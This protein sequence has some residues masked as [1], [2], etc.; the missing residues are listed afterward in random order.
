MKAHFGVLSYKGTGHLNPLI[1][2]SRQLVARGHRVTFFQSPEFEQKI[3]R[4]GLEFSAIR[5]HESHSSHS[6]LK[7][8]SRI[9]AMRNGVNRI[10]EDMEF[11]LQE[12]P[13]AIQGSGVDTL[14]IGEI[15][16]AG[17]TL[18]EM[19]RLPY[20]IVS[21]SIPHNFGW[22]APSFIAPTGSWLDRLQKYALEVS[23]LR[24]KGP[25]R[26]RLDQY[27][28][29]VG[30]GPIRKAYKAFPS[31]AHI[32]QVPQCLDLPRATLPV[33]FFYT[34]PFVDENTRPSIPF[35]W[36]RLD[37][38]PIIYASLGTTRKNDP[39]IFHRI[40]EACSDLDVQL[41]ITLGGRRDPALFVDLPGDPLVVKDAPQLELLKRAEI[42]IT[43]A[44]PNTVLETLMQGKPMLALPMV[45][46]QP[47]VATR[48]A[49]LNAAEVLSIPNRSS[50]QIRA[51]LVRLQSDASYR[52]AAKKI[53][54]QMQSIHGLK[55]ASDIIEAA[56]ARHSSNNT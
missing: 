3:L 5:V 25:V 23:V 21:T 31:L 54:A 29:R 41:V 8:S 19:L 52:D 16:L 34:A 49:R 18:A 4:H 11:F 14:L 26:R 35:P 9:A 22:N 53:Q 55:R 12:L 27:R 20:F 51:A 33:N 1:A 30:L 28:S 45:L 39:A 56:L 48:L 36:D 2:L 46:D 37:G 44:G 10:A 40:A 24:M 15:S 42:V 47:A 7:P 50:Q 32:T 13:A 38:R 43:H 6:K 17:P